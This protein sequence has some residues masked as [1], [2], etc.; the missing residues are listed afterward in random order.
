[1]PLSFAQRRLWFLHRLKGRAPT[2]NIPL[3]CGC[4]ARWTGRAATPR[5]PTW[6]RGTR[7]CGPCS[8]STDGVPAP[9][10]CRP[11]TRAPALPVVDR[12]PRPEL[13][14]LAGRGGRGTAST[15]PPRSRC[16]PAVRA[17]AATSTCCCWCVHHIAGD[18][19]SLAPLARDLA[20]AYAARRRGRGAGWAPLPVQ[21]ADY[22][23]WQRELLGDADDPDSLLAGQ[24]GYWRAALAGLPEQLALP[25]DRPRPAV[26]GHRGEPVPVRAGR[27]PAP[28]PAGAGA[29][30]R[31]AACSW[32]CRPALAALL[33][34]LG[35]GHRHPGR[36]PGRRAGPTRRW[37]TWS[38]SSST[39]W[40]CAPT[41]GDPSFR[42]LLGRVR[43]T[44]LAAYAHQDVP[45]ERLVEAL[46]PDRSLAR[47]PLFQVMLGAR[48][49]HRDRD[50]SS[51]AAARP[52]PRTR[53]PRSST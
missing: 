10:S 52:E 38:G 9:A 45:F 17:S 1:M 13:A 51:R 25:A 6:W 8:P 3:A 46:N 35:A 37:T 33:S 36:H 24:L 4:G 26:A 23:L 11:L 30:A 18:G 28:A 21:Y 16:G 20:A 5:W 27:R 15:S 12:R 50:A 44:D 14:E 32:C 2:Y 53:G 22:T 49:Q 40:C 7:A 43:E 34:R 41:S 42:E 47:H 39:P 19:W 29:G 31:G 48:Q